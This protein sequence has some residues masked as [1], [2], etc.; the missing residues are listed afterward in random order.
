MKKRLLKM[1][2]ACALVV[3]LLSANLV[4]ANTS[5]VLT[6]NTAAQTAVANGAGTTASAPSLSYGKQVTTSSYEG[7]AVGGLVVDGNHTTRWIANNQ[8][9]NPWLYVDLEKTASIDSIVIH[10][11]AA[12]PPQYRVEVSNDANSWEPIQ[13]ISDGGNSEAVI[14]VDVPENTSARYVRI[15]TIQRSNW[16][17]S[18][19]ELE[20][21][22]SYPVDTFV[23]QIDVKSSTGKNEIT[24]KGR[25]LQMT[26]QVSPEDASDKRVAWSVT[27]ENG[28]PTDVASISVYGVL[29]PNKNGTVKVTAAAV[30]GSN[31]LGSTL[32]QISGQDSKNLSIGKTASATASESAGPPAQAIDGNPATRWA[33]G[34]AGAQDSITVDLGSLHE[35]RDVTLSWEAAYGVKYAIQ[36]SADGIDYRTVYTEENGKGGIEDITFTPAVARY[37]RMQG[38]QTLPNLAYSLWEFEIYGEVISEEKIQE[39]VETDKQNLTIDSQN[40]NKKVQIELPVTGENGTLI[41]WES[42]DTSYITDNG[43]IVNVDKAEDK[44][45]TLKATLSIGDVTA[46]R[47]FPV[48]LKAD[49][50]YVKKDP[51]KLLWVGDSNSA[52]G[53]LTMNMRKLIKEDYGDWGTGYVTLTPRVFF[54]SD[55]A[56][57]PDIMP[58]DISF[59]YEGNWTETLGGY[60][61]VT[62]SPNT[63]FIYGNNKGSKLT[64]DFIGTGIDLFN[65]SVSGSGNYRAVLDGV[66]MGIVDQAAASYE[67][68]V[69]Q[70]FEGLKYGKHRLEITIQDQRAVNFVGADVISGGRENRSVIHT[71]AKGGASS[72]DF[73]VVREQLFKSVV[74]YLEPNKSVVLL[75]TNDQQI[76]YTP[77]QFEEY[78][79]TVVNRIKQAA[80]QSENWILSTFEMYSTD[81]VILD[82]LKQYWE[83]SFPKIAAETGSKY[84]AMGQWFG[85]YTPDKMIDPWHVNQEYGMKIVQELY[86]MWYPPVTGVTLDTESKTLNVYESFELTANVQPQEAF[87]KNVIWESSNENVA[88]VEKGVVTAKGAGTATITVTTEDGGFTASCEVTVV[89]LART[90]LKKTIDQAKAIKEAGYAPHL[91]ESVKL[92]FEAALEEAERVYL[93]SSATDA[94]IFEADDNLILM[95]H[96]LSFTAD[97]AGL[98]E[99]VLHAKEVAASGEYVNDDKMITYQNLIKAAEEL[100]K[101]ENGTATDTEF[102]AA[103]K[104]LLDAEEELTKA[105]IPGLDL[106]ALEYKVHFA[107]KMFDNLEK[108]IDDD[109]RKEFVTAFTAAK[110]LLEN[111]LAGGEGITQEAVNSATETLNKAMAK[112]RLIP[113]KDE[114]ENLL[115][116]V[117]AINLSLYTTKSA[118]ALQEAIT[119]AEA[120]LSDP[121]A[122]ESMV[123][124]A[125]IT[126]KAAKDGLVLKNSGDVSEPD[127]NNGGKDTPTGDASPFGG[128]LVL[129]AAALGTLAVLKKRK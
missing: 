123:K 46:T 100:L 105:V 71:L 103:V 52:I 70:T 40:A 109:A 2:T 102:A 44:T 129:M 62:D 73:Y 67:D 120:V 78:M 66:D 10:W 57:K 126:L 114:L 127:D 33:S 23:S 19:Y 119:A 99:A 89:S 11:E 16:G 84:W 55:F 36:V 21:G 76:K 69:V 29:T 82:L 43:I 6:E 95:M 112:L 22:G 14:T 65:F 72:Y 110:A 28:A 34:R 74:E 87:N 59:T 20:I 50:G 128:L 63:H 35:V 13:T 77:A 64:I 118:D 51:F 58:K 121:L 122:D 32:I 107:Q 45:I 85:P 5:G 96:Y 49:A 106:D 97:P 15:Y 80:P 47:E 30:D 61:S 25:P 7:N 24:R 117:K 26:A 42:S 41:Y 68:T 108:Y 98:K 111:A 31:V 79:T 8:E 125:M 60:G 88:A 94:Q 81:Q 18:M 54:F 9:A 92:K 104:S 113:N 115:K 116:K 86:N 4:L 101:N 3:S 83:V 37:V 124:G 48:P 39:L 75:G 56:D 38:L 91:I 27:D 12:R 90:L 53:Y 17:A 1:I 93:D